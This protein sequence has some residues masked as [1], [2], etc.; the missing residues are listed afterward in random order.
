MLP[1]NLPADVWRL[2]LSFL[3]GGDVAR[4]ARVS[5]AWAE[6]SYLPIAVSV[7]LNLVRLE[8]PEF[9]LPPSDRSRYGAVTRCEL[10]ACEFAGNE[11]YFGFCSSCFKGVPRDEA[12]RQRHL[13]SWKAKGERDAKAFQD[14]RDCTT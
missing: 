5:H 8:V 6:L 14:V 12:V 1:F 3:S 7:P 10:G 9:Q 2:I 13:A 11:A 4:V